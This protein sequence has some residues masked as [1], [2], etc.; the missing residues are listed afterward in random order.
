MRIRARHYISPLL[1]VLLVLIVS[2]VLAF[3]PSGNYNPLRPMATALRVSYS[4]YLGGNSAD[5]VQAIAVDNEGC[6][7]ILGNTLSDNFPTASPL[8]PLY[9]GPTAITDIFIAKL[10]AEGTALIYSTYLGGSGADYG[11]DIAVDKDGNVYVTG[12]TSSTDFPVTAGAFRNTSSNGEDV[13]VAK[14]NAEGTALVYS[15]YLGGSGFER[16]NGIAVDS[17]GNVYVAG[18]TTS[19]DFPV[20]GE[21]FQQSIKGFEDAFVTKV[22]ADGTALVYSTY[23]GGNSGLDEATDLALDSENNVYLTGGTASINFP[24]TAKSFQRTFGGGTVF[25]GDGYV[26][27]INSSGSA[28]IYS[29][30]LG[31]AGGDLCRAIAVDSSN[32]AYVTGTTQ[33]DNFPTFRARQPVKGGDCVD[34][35]S[36]CT[37][38]FVTKLN[39]SGSALIYSTYLGGGSRS[40][41]PLAGGDSGSGIVVDQ[42]GNAYVTGTT[43]SN[44]FPVVRAFQ[45]AR[46]GNGDTFIG[47]VKADGSELSYSTYFGGEGDESASDISIDG[48][49]NVYVAGIATSAGFPVTTGSFQLSF[50]GSFESFATARDGFIFKIASDAPRITSVSINGKKL[51]VVG[52]NF[53]AGAELFIDGKRQ[54]KT[55]NDSANPSALLIAKKSGNKLARRGMATLVVKNPGGLPSA[56][57]LF[58]RED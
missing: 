36:N 44:D 21:A 1:A 32:N 31:G 14:I 46:A 39:S 10:N 27:R 41:T 38:A 34:V 5:E 24:T 49:G 43:G 25:F 18:K 11:M 58:V 33:S 28:L 50:A 26:T 7:Y 52:E 54:K 23:L 22:N 4:T 20:T 12:Y 2:S 48:T 19:V 53:E 29:T 17:A 56:P 37:D 47:R 51:F 16:G 30:Y 45:N 9:K 15:T 3:K 57:F 8:Q 6:V 35:F 55:F 42:L 40:Q 13:F